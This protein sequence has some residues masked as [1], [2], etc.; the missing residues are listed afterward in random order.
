M[1]YHL[2]L[3]CDVTPFEFSLAEQMLHCFHLLLVSF[4]FFCEQNRNEKEK[5]KTKA[6]SLGIHSHTK[7]KMAFKAGRP[8]GCECS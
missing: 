1:I 6:A 5:E 3:I 4:F 8:G 7:R 2:Q